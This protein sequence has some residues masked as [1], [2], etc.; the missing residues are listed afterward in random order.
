M[1]FK[2]TTSNSEEVNGENLEQ[3]LN[4]NEK[5]VMRAAK[6]LKPE[7]KNTGSTISDQ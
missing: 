7:G 3:K 6:N 5:T 2:E 4:Y 1:C